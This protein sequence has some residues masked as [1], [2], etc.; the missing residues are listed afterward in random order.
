MY[1][2]C[3]IKMTHTKIGSY[4]KKTHQTKTLYDGNKQTWNKTVFKKY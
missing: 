1:G 2:L 4:T 3:I